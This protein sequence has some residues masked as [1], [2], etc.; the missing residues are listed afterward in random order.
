[1]A[2]IKEIAKRANVS[3]G[4]VDRVLHNRGR[5]SKETK[6][7][8]SKSLIGFAH[9][10]ETKRKMS[11]SRTGK[12][13]P[14]YGRGEWMKGENNPAKRPEVREKIRQAKIGRKRP[15]VAKRNRQRK[16]NG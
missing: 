3:I 6:E 1:M 5:V 12:N 2:T 9:S 8:I 4:T 14:N 13:N 7:K 16:F 10:E 15:D 11:K